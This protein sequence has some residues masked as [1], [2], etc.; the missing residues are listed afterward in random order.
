MPSPFPGMNPYLEQSYDWEEFHLNF[1]ARMQEYL[2]ARIGPKYI[3][4]AEVRLLLHERSAS[5]RGFIGK[6][7]VGISSFRPPS[8]AGPAGPLS[9]PVQLRLPA[10]EVEKQPY[11]EIRDVK[12][13]RVITVIE[14]LSP[15]NKKPGSDRD[16]YLAKRQQIL[17]QPVHLVEI[18]LRRGG[19][20]PTPPDLPPSDYYVLVSKCEDRPTVG[21]WPFG[22][23][24]PLPVV[25][26][27]LSDPE[28]AVPLDLKA[29]LDHTYDA[30][31]YGDHIYLETP[32]PPLSAEDDAWARGIAG[33]NPN[34]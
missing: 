34:P 24:D 7:D 3:V 16:M 32:E 27:P 8:G 19:T 5:E 18:D 26:V 28:P 4:K 6:G 2:H 23:R 1:I 22:L 21:V 29:I 10:V 15:S 31:G 11:L 20:R 33:K 13:R 9:A 25:P 12:N 17:L 14:L 30:V